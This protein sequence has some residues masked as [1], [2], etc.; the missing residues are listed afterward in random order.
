MPSKIT[1]PGKF[2]SAGSGMR[3]VNGQKNVQ[4]SANPRTTPMA[5]MGKH[6]SGLRGPSCNG[7]TQYR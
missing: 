3:A 4:N 6:G 7:M 5:L 1:G 2:M